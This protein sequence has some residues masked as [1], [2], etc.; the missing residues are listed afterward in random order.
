MADTIEPASGPLRHFRRSEHLARQ[1]G[2][3]TGLYRIEE[4]W[5]CQYRLMKDG[6]RQ[7]TALFLPGIIVSRN[8]Y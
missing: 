3:M 2:K 7:I 6:R 8:G 5:A 1:S 4:G